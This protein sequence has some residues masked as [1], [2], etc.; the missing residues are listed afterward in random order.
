MA[1]I[2]V[3]TGGVS[4]LGTTTAGRLA[5]DGIRVVTTDIA[6]RRTS[7]PT[8]APAAVAAAAEQI[9][10]V[11]ILVIRRASSATTS[12]CGRTPNWSGAELSLGKKLATICPWYP[13]S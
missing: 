13:G 7:L 8:S 11:D 2:A 10:T 12:R 6:S 3:I 5:A 9:G 4:G 1:R